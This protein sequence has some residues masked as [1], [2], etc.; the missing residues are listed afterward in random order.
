MTSVVD[1][2]SLLGRTSRTFDLSIPLLSEPHADHL[3]LAYLLYRLADTLEDAEGKPRRERLAALAQF[4]GVLK[5][6]DP[7]A[8]IRVT[9]TWRRWKPSKHAGYVELIDAFP[10][11]IDAVLDLNRSTRR[12]IVTHLQR[13]VSGMEFFVGQSEDDG[14]FRLRSRDSLQKYCYVVAG[15]VGEMI[16][17]LFIS[18]HSHLQAVAKTLRQHAAAFGEGLQL[19]NILKDAQQDARWG[20][21]YLPSCSTRSEI[22]HLAQQDLVKADRWIA[23]L[24]TGNADPGMIAFGK[25][26]VMLARATLDLLERQ[27]PGAKLSRS[28]VARIVHTVDPE[29]R[30]LGGVPA[31]LAPHCT[32]QIKALT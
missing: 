13:T 29:F 17:E 20:R 22:I 19:V 1:F 3:T 9:T 23:A 16:T 8:A 2:R 4:R 26:P 5:I 12:I 30:L 32:G 15:I 27:G 10:A 11:M 7:V 6:L 14:S 21:R 31:G 18:G 24:E 25:L 28:Q